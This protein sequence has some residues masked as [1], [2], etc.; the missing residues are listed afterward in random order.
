[1][2]VFFLQPHE[3]PGAPPVPPF[4][5]GHRQL[6]RLLLDLRRLECAGRQQERGAFGAAARGRQVEGGLVAVAAADGGGVAAGV[7]L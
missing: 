5:G 1:M 2:P 7:E 6:Q 3:Q 4:F